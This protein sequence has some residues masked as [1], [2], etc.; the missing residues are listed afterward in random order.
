MVVRHQRRGR[1]AGQVTVRFDEVRTP[2][3][4]PLLVPHVSCSCWSQYDK[5]CR[6]SAA[7]LQLVSMLLA[8]Y[9]GAVDRRVAFWLP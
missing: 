7:E 8:P 3:A 2:A 1:G 5:R 9:A 4:G 6:L